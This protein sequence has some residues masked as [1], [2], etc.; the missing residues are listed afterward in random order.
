MRAVHKTFATILLLFA[1]GSTGCN[2]NRVSASSIGFE[3]G[4]FLG[5]ITKKVVLFYRREAES[6]ISLLI[7]GIT[8][9]NCRLVP[10][11]E[12][13]EAEVWIRHNLT[14]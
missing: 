12:L 9:P 7:T 8:H 10:Y 13:K 1:V 14:Q 11:S 4:Y 2:R 6:K 5:A 3:T